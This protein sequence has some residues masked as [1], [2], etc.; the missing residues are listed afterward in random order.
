MKTKT[1]TDLTSMFDALRLLTKAKAALYAAQE[2]M[3]AGR[4]G[5]LARELEIA[6][7]GWEIVERR[8][9]VHQDL[10]QA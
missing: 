4:V 9:V 7:E 6:I 1:T 8:A 5:G 2:P 3:M 10:K